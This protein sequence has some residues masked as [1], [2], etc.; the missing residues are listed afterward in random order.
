MGKRR[1]AIDRRH[2][3]TQSEIATMAKRNIP[4]TEPVANPIPTLDPNHP[5]I[6]EMI[7]SAVQVALNHQ[8]A[9]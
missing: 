4:V 8:R 3:L 7:A 2:R 6:L 1:T 5:Q 9:E